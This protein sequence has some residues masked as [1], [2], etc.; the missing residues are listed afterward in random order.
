MDNLILGHKKCSTTNKLI[1]LLHHERIRFKLI[2]VV[3]E[4]M[5]KNLL[6]EIIKLSGKEMN[7]FFNKNNKYFNEKYGI[8]YIEGLSDEEKLALLL[9]HGQIMKRPILVLDDKVFV[10]FDVHAITNYILETTG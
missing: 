8:K 6:L 1:K 10:G 2:D 4:T 5:D 9:E 7:H 3:E